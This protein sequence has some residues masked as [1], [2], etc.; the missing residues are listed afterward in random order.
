TLQLGAISFQF[1]FLKAEIELI[2]KYL[3]AGENTMNSVFLA[4]VFRMLP[5][6]VDKAAFRIRADQLHIQPIPDIHVRF[7]ADQPALGR[8]IHN[9]HETSLWRH[10]RHD[11]GERLSNAIRQR[12]CRDALIHNALDLSRSILPQGAI[13]SYRRKIRIR[14]RGGLIVEGSL[15]ES[16]RDQV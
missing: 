9:P 16:L 3:V 4:D 7:A 10:A 11:G 12:Y 5:G 8:R 15:N 2:V 1:L 6:E 14:V 13:A